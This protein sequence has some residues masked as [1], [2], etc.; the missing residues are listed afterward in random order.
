MSLLN[1]FTR[2]LNLRDFRSKRADFYRHLARSMEANELLRT[3]LTDE[4]KIAR[5]KKTADQSKARALAEML[6]RLERSEDISLVRIIGSVIPDSDRMMLAAV[7]QSKD[8]P[9]TL[10]DLAKAIDEQHEA[11]Q[12]IVKALITPVILIPGI[13]AFSMILSTQVIPT[14]AQIA[15]PEVWTPFL[16]F[17]RGL[18][19]A[20]ARFG[21]PAAVIFIV[22]GIAFSLALPKVTGRRRAALEQIS[23]RTATLLF[24]F[25]PFLL[26]MAMYRDFVAGQVLTTLA[27]LLNSGATL[28]SAL[29]TIQQTG[30]PYVRWHMR[31][32]LSH[33]ELYSTDYVG[34]FGKGLLSSSLL[35]SLASTIR[36]NPKFDRVLV[37]LGTTGNKKIRDQVQKSAV[38]IN[39][40]L[41][42]SGAILIVVLYAGQFM[43]ALETQDAMDPVKRMQRR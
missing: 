4:G 40:L 16:S 32:I 8:K 41:L 37:E 34:S 14:I 24:P 17:I 43:L 33:L 6:R 25:A 2:W 30:T 3:Y 9:Q 42:T 31:R 15:P 22:L 10:R 7:D 20:I 18:A 11:R 5:S 12:I 27:V 29:K 38:I 13:F 26:P 23:P 36:N 1:G 19:Y 21:F 35:A 39:A 28:N